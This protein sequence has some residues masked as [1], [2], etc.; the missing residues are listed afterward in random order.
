MPQVLVDGP[1]NKTE[2]AVPRHSAALKDCSLT[3]IVIEKLPR[4]AGNGAVK[5]AW[6]KAGVDQKWANSTWAKTR[7]QSSKRRAL[8]DFE[9]FKVMRLRKQVSCIRHCSARRWPTSVGT[10]Q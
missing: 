8:T 3:P 2:I 5:A 4:A 6:E 10:G 9:K 7:E 1:A